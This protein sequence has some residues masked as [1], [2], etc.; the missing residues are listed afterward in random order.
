MLRG[1]VHS[2]DHYIDI[3]NGSSP[4]L[5]TL[6][7]CALVALLYHISYLSFIGRPLVLVGV[8]PT[9]GM[10]HVGHACTGAVLAQW[11][12]QGDW[13]WKRRYYNS[14]RVPCNGHLTLSVFFFDDC[15]FGLGL[16]YDL[17]AK[18][19][20]ALKDRQDNIILVL[21]LLYATFP[22]ESSLDFRVMWSLHI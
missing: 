15:P 3:K 14:R 19:D 18:R 1:S 10:G 20:S 7:G 22:L 4:G 6:G 8:L 12:H 21:T 2:V 16:E 17:V 13:D 11:D 5:E 9:R